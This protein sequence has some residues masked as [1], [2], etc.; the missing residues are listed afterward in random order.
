MARLSKLPRI[1]RLV[2]RALNYRIRI[3]ND[4][5]PSYD[6]LYCDRYQWMQLNNLKVS[7]RVLN[8]INEKRKL[9]DNFSISHDKRLAI[10]IPFRNRQHHLE[11]LLPRLTTKLREDAI[12]HRIFV[13][14]QQDDKLFNRAKLL[15]V[16][17]HAAG[18]S[19]DYYCFHDVD[20]QPVNCDYGCPSSPLRLISNLRSPD[21]PR[22]L[23]D[24]CFGGV[25]SVPRSDFLK[26]NGFDNNFWHW[27]KEDDN[28]LLRLLLS[29]S[30][31][32]IDTLG[33]FDEFSGSTNR[34]IL[35]ATKADKNQIA[36]SKKQ[37]QKNRHRQK[38]AATGRIDPF[39]DGLSTL[40]YQLME[41][42]RA[43]DYELLRVKL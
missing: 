23:S 17:A 19:Y 8:A 20:M 27:G 1:H 28:F 18:E 2:G 43:P 10:I 41:R 6:T 40:Q 26:A 16:G 7:Q 33:T 21:G 32:A 34:H 39:A 12:D 9:P 24:I 29:G 22:I 14:E 30:T 13:V 36:A 42:I 3:R 25:T 15:N 38:M 37:T 5:N 11:Q 35:S 4:H 31:P